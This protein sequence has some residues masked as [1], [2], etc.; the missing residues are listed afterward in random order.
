M[1]SVIAMKTASKSLFENF[2]QFSSRET[3]GKYF[4]KTYTL[5]HSFL[6]YQFAKKSKASNKHLIHM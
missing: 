3:Y 5:L 4:E 2:R 6:Q 1:K